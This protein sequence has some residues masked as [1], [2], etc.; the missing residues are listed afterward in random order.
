[1]AE[2]VHDVAEDADCAEYVDHGQGQ[3]GLRGRGVGAPKPVN[4]GEVKICYYEIT[5][6]DVS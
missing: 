5:S 3:G 2:S 1:M 4:L 6:K